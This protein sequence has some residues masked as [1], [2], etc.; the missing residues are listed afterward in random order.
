ME[1]VAKCACG[2]ASVQVAGDVAAHAVCHCNN[3][4][5]RTG[6]AFGISVYFPKLAIVSVAGPL[7]VYAPYNAARK[8]DQERHFCSKC[9]TTLY[10]YASTLPGMVGIA[11][12][13]FADN[14]VGEPSMTASHHRKWEWVSIPTHWQVLPEG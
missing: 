12:G 4:K 2:A 13:C 9:G 1:R 5:K 8:E 3:C 10:W 14:P 11:G 7:T 6:S